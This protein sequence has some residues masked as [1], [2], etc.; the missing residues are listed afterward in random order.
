MPSKPGKASP[1]TV[2]PTPAARDIS[3]P[4]SVRA[5]LPHVWRLL[6][7]VLPSKCWC[8]PPPQLRCQL[9][10]EAFPGSFR[11]Q[12][13]LSLLA[14]HSPCTHLFNSPFYTV[15][16][17]FFF[18]S[19]TPDPELC[20]WHLVPEGNYWFETQLIE[21]WHRSAFPDLLYKSFV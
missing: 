10:Q 14:S 18:M 6:L 20:T 12:E 1:L 15:L 16:K 3:I 2:L 11:I 5:P 7:G 9:L 13:S 8:T 19:S 4:E 17:L 21:G